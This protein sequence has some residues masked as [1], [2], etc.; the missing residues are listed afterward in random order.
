MVNSSRR[1]H[2]TLNIHVGEREDTSYFSSNP[3][4]EKFLE[5]QGQKCENNIKIYLKKNFVACRELGSIRKLMVRRLRYFEHENV[6][7]GSI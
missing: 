2:G 3:E 7:L 6:I 4:K 1:T 5:R